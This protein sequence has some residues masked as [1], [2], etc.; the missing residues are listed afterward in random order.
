M[1]MATCRASRG[2]QACRSSWGI[3]ALFTLHEELCDQ[4]ADRMQPQPLQSQLSVPTH[5][6][7]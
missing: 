2:M 4:S 6:C 3:A 7:C 1:H 5:S